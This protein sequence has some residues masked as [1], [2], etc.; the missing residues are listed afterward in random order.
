MR[1]A[2][3]LQAVH[4]LDDIVRREQLDLTDPQDRDTALVELSIVLMRHCSRHAVRGAARISRADAPDRAAHT[5]A[6]RALQIRTGAP[7]Q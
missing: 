4:R 2:S 3:N 6:A 1:R 7:R 5:V